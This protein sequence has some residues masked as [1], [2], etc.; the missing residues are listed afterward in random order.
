MF[1]FTESEL[2]CQEAAENNKDVRSGCTFTNKRRFILFAAFPLLNPKRTFF[3]CT[4]LQTEN[5]IRVKFMFIY[6][7]GRLKN[8]VVRRVIPKRIAM[9][10][11]T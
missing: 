8:E 5:Q 10:V 7:F 9:R 2:I 1:L 11:E 3:L 4:N 6:G